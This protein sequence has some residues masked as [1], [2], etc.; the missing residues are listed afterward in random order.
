MKRERFDRD[1]APAPTKGG[2][3]YF[4]DGPQAD[5]FSSGCT[6]LNLVLG[7]KGWA[8]NR[9][10]NLVGDK[11]TGK[12]LL[13]IEAAANF[14]RKY[15]TAPIRYV[16]VESAFDKD[17]A[18]S[19]GLPRDGI[20]FPNEDDLKISTIEDVFRDLEKVVAR[21]K[22]SLYIIDSLDA[23]SDEAEV[24]REVGQAS[25]AMNK[26]KQ[27]SAMFRKLNAK[28]AHA[29]TTVIVVS[30]V[31]DAIGVTFGKKHTRAGGRALDF[32]ASQ[33]VWLTHLKRLTR[34]RKNITRP[35]G[36]LIRAQAEKSKVGLPFREAEFPVYFNYGVEDVVSMVDWLKATKRLKPTFRGENAA[37]K[38]LASL[39]RISP[40]EYRAKQKELRR[41]VK[42]AWADIERGFVVTRRKYA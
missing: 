20:T 37:A 28:L 40:E 7:G 30:Q 17:Y 16:E 39:D 18:H 29:K 2:G 6:L 25:F 10:A 36:V 32:Y 13:A 31:R 8:E 24:G 14:R 5:G 1:T 27:L 12:T 35:Y 26:A 41:V 19:V 11:S 23:L 9:I 38:F 22:R 34:T 3:L 21:G 42:E 33:I 4:R 15:P